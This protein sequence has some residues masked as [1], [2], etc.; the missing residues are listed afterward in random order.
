MTTIKL[1][2]GTAAEW[3]AANPILAAGEMGIE[4]DTRKFKFGDG[5]THWNTL[6]YASAEGGGGTGDVTAAGDNKF[7]GKNTFTGEVNIAGAPLTV[8]GLAT[9]NQATTTYLNATSI[10]SNGEINAVSIKANGLRSDDIQTTTNK[11]YL[12]EVDV[13]NQTIQIVNGKLHANL[14]E[15]GNEVND[16][17]GRVT[18]N[19]ADIQSLTTSLDN[20]QNILFNGNGTSI[21]NRGLIASAPFTITGTERKFIGTFSSGDI[22]EINMGGMNGVFNL[23]TSEG[24]VLL[25]GQYRQDNQMKTVIRFTSS[26]TDTLSDLSTNSYNYDPINTSIKVEFLADNKQNL[27][28]SF[29]K[30]TSYKQIFTTSVKGITDGKLY[31]GTGYGSTNTQTVNYLTS[32]AETKTTV[33]INQGIAGLTGFDKYTTSTAV[34]DFQTDGGYIVDNGG[35]LYTFLTNRG[36][37]NDYEI[38]IHSVYLNKKG[39]AD[40]SNINGVRC[41]PQAVVPTPGEKAQGECWF[42]VFNYPFRVVAASSGGS[43]QAQTVDY[44]NYI[45]YVIKG[46]NLTI[47][48]SDTGETYTELYTIAI[49]S[50]YVINV[51]IGNSPWSND[52]GD[53]GTK[54]KVYSDTYIKDNYTNKYIVNNQIHPDNVAIATSTQY[55]LVLPD[56]STIVSN[57]GVI[58]ANIPDTSKFL[59]KTTYSKQTIESSLIVNGGVVDCQRFRMRSSGMGGIEYNNTTLGKTMF[60]FRGVNGDYPIR[61]GDSAQNMQ[62]DSTKVLFNSPTLVRKVDDSTEA[63]IIDSNNISEYISKP[64]AFGMSQ[65]CSEDIVSNSWLKSNGQYNSGSVYIDFYNW[66]LDNT[67]NNKDGFKLST[68]TDITDYDFVVNTTE[69]TFRLPLLNGSEDLIGSEVVNYAVPTVG[70]QT[71]TATHNGQAQ[72]YATTTAVSQFIRITNVTTGTISEMRPPLGGVAN[73]VSTWVNRGDTFKIDGDVVTTVNSVQ[74]FK[75]VG[76][77]S[78]YYYCGDTI[79]SP[80]LINIAEVQSTLANKLDI[81]LA[82]QVCMPSNRYTDLTLGANGTTYTA[83]ADG[84]FTLAKKL[85][86][87]GQF[88]NLTNNTTFV[89]IMSCNAFDDAGGNTA[90]FVPCKKGDEIVSWYSAGGDVIF[91]RFVYAEGAQ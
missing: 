9:L 55:G 67:N 76:N 43:Y 47:S 30:G 25:N 36:A 40:D 24:E 50:T 80:E 17:S 20:K 78:L 1:R 44:I 74:L 54:C 23:L 5:T 58:S 32:S 7:T 28:Y 87:K 45:K 89:S 38:V 46:T 31:L 35:A 60:V 37:N 16:L 73:V 71:Y 84:Y 53:K 81:S 41:L 10:T 83:P 90:C 86:A 8:D 59:D 22:V 29:N 48:Y 88:V 33:D 79:K 64:Y 77:G 62:I 13:D 70:G 51:C 72:L 11:K 52:I 34:V 18:A 68:A 49:S 2:R 63:T 85:T 42:D 91:F 39:T 6:A 15:L 27:Y 21:N 65:Y 3:T 14:D 61:I 26:F 57:N 4:T 69:Q 19:E 66:V 12:T 56:N 82:S 75:A